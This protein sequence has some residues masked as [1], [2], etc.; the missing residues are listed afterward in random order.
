VPPEAFLGSSRRHN[1]SKG[2]THHLEPHDFMCIS[3]LQN[4]FSPE[5]EWSYSKCLLVNLSVNIMPFSINI[6]MQQL[7][8]FAENTIQ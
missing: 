2:N 6:F 1:V 4:P 7:F 8:P 3:R 5:K